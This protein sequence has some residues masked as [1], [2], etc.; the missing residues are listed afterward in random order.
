[1]VPI[2]LGIVTYVDWPET[3]LQVVGREEVGHTGELVK[4]VVFESEHGRR[5]NNS[6]LGV[7]RANQFLSRS[8]KCSFSYNRPF[9]LVDIMETDLGSEVLGGRVL[10]SVVRRNVHEAVDIVFRSSIRNTLNTVDI[11]IGVGEVPARPAH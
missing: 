7:D 5:T 8:L 10:V 2:I 6:G 9:L 11:N 3:L 1:M 4:Q